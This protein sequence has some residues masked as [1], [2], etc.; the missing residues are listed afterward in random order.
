MGNPKVIREAH[1][2]PEMQTDRALSYLCSADMPTD[3]ELGPVPSEPAE[4]E[5]RV[6][7]NGWKCWTIVQ[8]RTHHFKPRSGVS[9]WKW[10]AYDAVW[11]SEPERPPEGYEF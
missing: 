7:C 5:R 6:Y 10:V 3:A 4:Q 1:E 11:I 8:Y 9:Y 2:R